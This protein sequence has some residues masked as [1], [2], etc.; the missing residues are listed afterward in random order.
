L[1]RA[2]ALLGD[3]LADDRRH[4]PGGRYRAPRLKNRRRDG[5]AHV[6][7]GRGRHLG[8]N[9]YDRDRAWRDGRSAVRW[10]MSTLIAA[11]I[12]LVVTAVVVYGSL[13]KKPD[14]PIDILAEIEAAT[15]TSSSLAPPVN[16]RTLD[17]VTPKQDR[18]QLATTTLI[19]RHVIHEQVRVRRNNRPFL[20]I[21]PYL[22]V[23]ARL[24]PASR[25]Y[26]DIIPPFNPT[27]L[28]APS[29]N[30]DQTVPE[31][32]DPGHGLIETAVVDLPD[33]RLPV[34]DRQSLQPF[35]V[36]QLVAETIESD[37][38]APSV[39]IGIE[40]QLIEG[41]TPGYLS[42]GEFLARDRGNAAINVTTL[43]RTVDPV[44][45]D[46]GEEANLDDVRI[47]SPRDGE[48]LADLLAREGVSN[49][50][51]HRVQEAA[52][53]VIGRFQLRVGQQVMVVMRPTGDSGFN[54][55]AKL[56]VFNVGQ[57]HLVSVRVSAAGRVSASR[58]PD[59]TALI[60]AMN[61]LAGDGPRG[62]ELYRSVYALGLN[63]G[64]APQQILE[65]LRIHATDTDYRSR[66]RAGDEIEAFFELEPNDRGELIPTTLVYTSLTTGGETRQYWRYRSRDGTV[67]YFDEFGQNN[68]QFLLRKPVRGSNVRLTSGYGMRRHPI[69]RVYKMHNGIDWAAQTGT[70]IVAAGSGVVVQA[71]R[72]RFN[73]NFIRIKHAN[74]Y[75]TTYS[76]LHRF[77]AGIRAGVRV[78]QGQVIGSVG[79][80]GLSTGAHLHLEVK[81]NG[82]NVDP[83][84]IPVPRERVLK[85]QEL[86]D[87]QRERQRIT[88]VMRLPPVRVASS[89]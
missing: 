9:I 72:L 26:A 88:T 20:Q 1:T 10:V 12:S 57:V 38:G 55:P 61:S 75:E 52:T 19:A 69:R 34:S 67:D 23:R 64:L 22:R 30:S 85:A 17:W 62:A 73:G 33:G 24:A 70:P 37:P 51:A 59:Q 56:S 45:D 48:Y 49:E 83:L 54:S 84:K 79:S 29:T 4:T 68:R 78:R 39:R 40:Q 18:L 13:D 7:Q 60:M 35:E 11:S 32:D 27:R 77:G 6:K 2:G 86:K 15:Q 74:G 46:A 28:Y 5:L 21:K 81:I 71:Q 41:L 36:A 16:P 82:R 25:D 44:E 47:L 31:A 65:I 14:Q 58:A 50:I 80:T 66:I 3:T 53:Q 43:T 76:H 63:Q 87:F 89:Q 8:R 42:G